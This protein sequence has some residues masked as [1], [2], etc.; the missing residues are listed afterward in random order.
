MLC[1]L[2]YSTDASTREERE[3][4]LW[5]LVNAALTPRTASLM[6]TPDYW[7]RNEVLNQ[8]M[9][10][11]FYKVAERFYAAV[12]NYERILFCRL[13]SHFYRDVRICAA[14]TQ[15]FADTHARVCLS[16]CASCSATTR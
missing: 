10:K 4:A 15:D 11:G 13:H 7:L 8:A 3:E 14:P 12:P 5:A 16:T 6:D 2:L 9:E 1:Y